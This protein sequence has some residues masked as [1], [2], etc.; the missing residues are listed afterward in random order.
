MPRKGNLREV[1]A[2]I[3]VP[4]APLFCT[5]TLSFPAYIN[6]ADQ[7]HHDTYKTKSY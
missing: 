3:L 4:H 6:I 2:D 1:L 5:S 7:K